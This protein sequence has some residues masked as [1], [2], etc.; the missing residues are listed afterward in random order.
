[1]A[2]IV[3]TLGQL[4]GSIGGLTFQNNSS[5]AIVRQRPQPAKGITTKQSNTH[6]N[7]IKWLYEWQ[8]LSQ[9]QRNLWNVYA[10]TWTKIN[11]FGEVKK[12]TGLNWFETSNYH[13][14]SIGESI[15]QSPPAHDL[16]QT[17]PSFNIEITD[18]IIYLVMNEAHDY[19]NYPVLVW[20]SQPIRRNTQTINQT[21]R[22]AMIITNLN[23]NPI[24]IKTEWE[25]ATELPFSPLSLFPNAN[26]FVCLQ[27]M[28]RT[29]GITST[30][31][32]KSVNTS[33]LV[34]M[35]EDFYYYL[36]PVT[37]PPLP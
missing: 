2:R 24:S 37:T 36:I 10:N 16:P 9:A 1:M 22:L 4:K 3:Y 30:L 33:L 6:V 13:I 15:L 18:T 17:P 19:Y 28:A 23:T 14:Q 20:V 34:N 7:H 29:S 35:Q 27:S 11:K 25:L 21:R 26:L 8:Q 32:C 31:L 5:G 12:L